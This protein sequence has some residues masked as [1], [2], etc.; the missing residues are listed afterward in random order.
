MNEE[1]T[2]DFQKPQ[3]FTRKNKHLSMDFASKM[4]RFM[5]KTIPDR[6]KVDPDRNYQIRY[7]PIKKNHFDGDVYVL[8]DGLTFSTG[9]FVAAKLQ[10]KRGAVIIGEETGGGGIGFNAVL[11]W[12]LMLPNSGVRMNLP[13]YHVDVI[14]GKD[15]LGRGV[16]PQISVSADVEQRAFNVD[17]VLQK[18]LEII[19]N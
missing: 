16:K 4:T 18:V 2:M 13:L 7:K 19:R 5:F 9:S 10:E 14:P 1:F 3:N 11:S 15:D 17:L 8:T 6:D 12:S